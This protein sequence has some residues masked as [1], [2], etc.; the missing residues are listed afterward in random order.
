[1][2][3]KKDKHPGGRPAGS[4]NK[5]PGEGRPKGGETQPQAEKKKLEKKPGEDK[6][7]RS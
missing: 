2:S 4:K 5:K 6:G 1:M 3:D 7:G